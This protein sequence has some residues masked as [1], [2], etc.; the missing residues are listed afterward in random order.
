[1]ITPEG[2]EHHE[3]IQPLRSPV[4]FDMEALIGY[5]LLI[6]VLLSVFLILL[7]IIWNWAATGR[8]ELHYSIQGMNF[9]RFS[10]ET[11][12]QVLQSGFDP[13]RVINLGIVTLLFTPYLRVFAS[14]IYFAVARR[15]W[16]YTLFTLFVFAVLTY[17]LLGR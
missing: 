15:D 17:S 13:E 10:M 11:V 6:G 14:V 4:R 2:T 12:R 5:I 7:G 9:L 16:K 3:P 8:S 1:M